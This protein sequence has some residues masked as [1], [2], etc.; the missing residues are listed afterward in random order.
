MLTVEYWSI[1]KLAEQLVK[2]SSNQIS[3]AHMS[4]LLIR[5]GITHSQF[6]ISSIALWRFQ[7]HFSHRIGLS[8]GH[9]HVWAGVNPFSSLHIGLGVVSRA[10]HLFRT[11]FLCL[12]SLL[13]KLMK[14][15]VT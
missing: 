8:S 14:T 12:F 13:C 7:T 10:Y 2:Q 5:W 11:H 4:E 3:A 6:N 1:D 15:Y 9:A